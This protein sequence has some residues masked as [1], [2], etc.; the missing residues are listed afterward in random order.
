M[1]VI[2]R[3]KAERIY[4]A[5]LVGVVGAVLIFA[6]LVT[7]FIDV[8]LGI[9]GPAAWIIEPALL[10]CILLAASAAA[11]RSWLRATTGAAAAGRLQLWLDRQ[12]RRRQIAFYLCSYPLVLAIGLLAMMLAGMNWQDM[13]IVSVIA[14]IG[15]AGAHARGRITRKLRDGNPTRE[16]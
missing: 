8:V 9:G 10:I 13:V 12:T 5:Y 6:A 2:V 15:A 11:R 16:S 3:T 14:V 4:A 1:G 7:G